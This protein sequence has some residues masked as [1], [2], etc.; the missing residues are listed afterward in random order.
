MPEPSDGSKC[1]IDDLMI[2][3][4]QLRQCHS[5]LIPLVGV[6]IDEEAL[7]GR[8]PEAAKGLAEQP[9]DVEAEGGVPTSA[10]SGGGTGVEA[11]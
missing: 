2:I 11:D 7:A 5:S 3:S 9:E 10:G 4:L 8:L 6:S 1:G